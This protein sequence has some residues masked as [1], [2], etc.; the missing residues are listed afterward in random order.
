[1]FSWFWR[2]YY[3]AR[4]TKIEVRLVRSQDYAARLEGFR[5]AARADS[6]SYRNS[7]A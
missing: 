1:M 5:V 3:K 6:A 7:K 2:A 4:D